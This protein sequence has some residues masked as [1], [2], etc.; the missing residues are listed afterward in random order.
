MLV[1]GRVTDSLKGQPA[2]FHR[3][4]VSWR[5]V[6]G[7][8][9]WTPALWAWRGSCWLQI[10]SSWPILSFVA[11]ASFQATAKG[12]LVLMVLFCFGRDQ[13]LICLSG[14][15]WRQAIGF[16]QCQKCFLLRKLERIRCF[17]G[18]EWAVPAEFLACDRWIVLMTQ[19][20]SGTALFYYGQQCFHCAID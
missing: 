18:S 16:S 5:S 2:H 1:G 15:R 12:L 10:A 20:C 13:W 3:K 14:H 7:S 19:R 11:W 4:K 9:I 8:G 17:H 6:V